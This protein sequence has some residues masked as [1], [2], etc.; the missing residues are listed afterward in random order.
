[1]VRA[2]LCERGDVCRRSEDARLGMLESTPPHC[3]EYPAF[4]LCFF[5]RA[6]DPPKPRACHIPGPEDLKEKAVAQDQYDSSAQEA[7]SL[8]AKILIERYGTT[9]NVD[10]VVKFGA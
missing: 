3:N 6:S 10:K 4:L 1:M 7:Q 5:S 8:E 9:F 2:Y